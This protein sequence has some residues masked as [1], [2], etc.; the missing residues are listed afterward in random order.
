M[1][2]VTDDRHIQREGLVG[3]AS[4]LPR[5]KLIRAVS[6]Q[7]LRL[8]YGSFS[9]HNSMILNTLEQSKPVSGHLF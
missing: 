7:V 5:L 1:T 6:I 3:Q 9:C 2:A 8:F 4:S